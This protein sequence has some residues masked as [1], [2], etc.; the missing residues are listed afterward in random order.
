ML[1]SAAYTRIAM[2]GRGDPSMFLTVPVTRVNDGL[3]VTSTWA[4][5][6]SGRISSTAQRGSRILVR[7]TRP[8]RR[9][10]GF[11]LA[12]S[13]PSAGNPPRLPLYADMTARSELWGE[14]SEA[15]GTEKD[16][17]ETASDEQLGDLHGVQRR[18]LA[19]V[20]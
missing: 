1:V 14:P 9:K 15:S 7:T 19:E 10:T 16:L 5:P 11:A 17:Y 18:A 20:V 2:L 6:I 8:P 4:C 12:I 13:S 3:H